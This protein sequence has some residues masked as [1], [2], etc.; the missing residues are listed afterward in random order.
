[1]GYSE[2]GGGGSVKWKVE[3]GGDTKKPADRDPKPTK[4][5]GGQFVVLIKA[6][7]NQAIADARTTIEPDGTVRVTC[8][9]DHNDQKQ[10]R[11]Y[12][13]P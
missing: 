1:M 11:I 2:F 6:G 10:I 13:T 8:D 4:E 7:A 5:E 9:I 12:W 3:H